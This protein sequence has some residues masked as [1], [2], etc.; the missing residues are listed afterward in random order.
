MHVTNCRVCESDKLELFLD[1]GET[2]LANQFVLPER[3]HEP[4]PRFPLRLVLC[5][6]CGLVQIDEVVP[7]EVL[8]KNYAYVSGTS[9]L[10]YRHARSLADHFCSTYSLGRSA[11]VVEAASNDGTVLQAF[12]RHGVRTVGIDPAENIVRCA[13][14]AGIE[15]V[16]DF[17]NAATAQALRDR[18]GPA[19]LVLARH[20]LAHVA[21]L[22][23]FVQ[24]FGILLDR[25]GVAAIEVPYLRPFHDRLEY[26]TVYH[27]HLCYF[28]LS[29]LKTLLERHGLEVL[30]VQEA[31]IHGGSILVTA[32]RRGGLRAPTD[33]VN[34]LLQEERQRGWHRP[35]LWHSFARAVARSKTAILNEID[36]L[37][38]SAR[39]LAGYG[40]P[41]KGMTLL[42]YCGIGP[43]RLPHLV[44]KSP[45]K[46]NL[47]TPGHHIPIA[48]PERLQL[49]PPDVLLVLAWN[50]AEEIV[51]Q[52]AEFG[53]RGKF[54][55]PLPEPHY[56][57]ER[58]AAA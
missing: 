10:I 53:R 3:V 28:S 9:D 47:L 39:K 34:Q 51:A 48:G 31:A 37:R 15:T 22:Q 46:Q 40:A 19:R 11:M 58:N 27:E 52:Q 12:K 1:L 8:F 16:C 55:L 43:D 32:Q 44:D 5:R 23:D 29:V 14:E 35:E 2:A 25:D 26:D 20:V 56:W 41:A 49:D 57:R 42:A 45:H 36:G 18:Y 54:L 21:D 17:F 50:F 38:A 30:N 24:G 6:V 4:E 7:P 13:N 33:L